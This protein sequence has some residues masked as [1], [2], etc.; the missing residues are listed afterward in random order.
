MSEYISKQEAIE[1]FSDMSDGI[2]I[3]HGD[4]ISDTAA[5]NVIKSIPSAN[6]KPVVHGEWINDPYEDFLP[7]C[8]NC[9][10]RWSNTENMRF[11]PHCGAKMKGE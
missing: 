2:P 8:S 4:M 5:V 11:C 9:K 1:A 7:H 3:T 6:V 10:S